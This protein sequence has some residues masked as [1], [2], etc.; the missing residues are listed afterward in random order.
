MP[1]LDKMLW[2]F[3]S[4]QMKNRATMAGNIA[5]A[6]PIGDIAP[7]LLALDAS[8]ELE[9]RPGHAHPRAGD[10]FTGYRKTA[11]APTR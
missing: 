11:L 3:A 7:V 9:R 2:V 4:R 6:S 8:I 1:P 5:T 10:F